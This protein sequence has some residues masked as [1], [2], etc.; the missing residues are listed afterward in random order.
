MGEGGGDGWGGEELW[1]QKAE[2]CSWTTIKNV[3]TKLI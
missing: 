3:K 1:G 2:N